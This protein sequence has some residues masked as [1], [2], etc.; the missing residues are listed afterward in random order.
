MH[1]EGLGRDRDELTVREI[2]KGI[3]KY[4]RKSSSEVHHYGGRGYR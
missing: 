1:I 3:E 4:G 2:L